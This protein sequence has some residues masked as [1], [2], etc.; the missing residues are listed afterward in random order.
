MLRTALAV[1]ILA[2]ALGAAEARADGGTRMG[3]SYKRT[4]PVVVVPGDARTIVIIK[5]QPRSCCRFDPRP[6]TREPFRGFRFMGS[7]FFRSE[8]TVVRMR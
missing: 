5:R 1:L 6:R 8:G 2:V 7:R 3:L 4:A